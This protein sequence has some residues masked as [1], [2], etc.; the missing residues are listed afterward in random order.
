MI[1][2]EV[3]EEAVHQQTLLGAKPL[4][5]KTSINTLFDSFKMKSED[6]KMDTA[7]NL[8]A[9]VSAIASEVKSAS[10]GNDGVD[11]LALDVLATRRFTRLGRGDEL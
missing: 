11:S 5:T 2:S 4:A 8:E 6:A 3:T 1:T 9:T 7:G 10:I